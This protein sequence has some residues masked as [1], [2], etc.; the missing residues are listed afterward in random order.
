M[1]WLDQTLL[2]SVVL[3]ASAAGA[4]DRL[5]V[6]GDVDLRWVHA[7]GDPSYL[8]GGLGKLRFD[9]E[10][11]GIRFGRAFLAPNWRVTD[12]FAVR[13]V[14]DADG[15]PDRNPVDLRAFF[16]AV[17]PVPTTPCRWSAPLLPLFLPDVPPNP[18]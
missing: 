12:I 2:W 11:E 14:V 3:W 1:R 8:N 13:A 5:N 15:D 6:S 17:L 7:T 18:G 16:S 10:H 9:P 4:Q